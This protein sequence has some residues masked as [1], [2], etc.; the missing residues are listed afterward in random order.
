MIKNIVEAIKEQ[1]EHIDGIKF[2][3]YERTRLN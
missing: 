1:A 2:F 3:K